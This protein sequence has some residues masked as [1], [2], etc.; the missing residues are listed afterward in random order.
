MRIVVSGGT[1]YI[2]S[3]V[4][5]RCLEHPS[6]T[7][8]LIL[9]RREVKE[10]ADHPKAKVIIVKD[11]TAYEKAIIDEIQT[12]DAA[13]WCLGTSY[14]DER[15]DIEF[16]L[17]FIDIIKA[18]P[19]GAKPFRYVQLSGALTEPPPPEGQ[20]PRSLWFFA[21]GRRV[22]GAMETKVLET[23][24]DDPESRFQMYLV[25]PGG[26]LPDGGAF[27][28]KWIM[29]DTLFIVMKEL[30]AAMVDLAVNGNEQRLFS[31]PELIK[32]GRAVVEKM[33]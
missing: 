23:A 15:V 30:G 33:K 11:F 10:L 28:Q 26:V 27:V 19:A 3:G 20:Q 17:A 9:S 7:S 6:V 22:R 14:G 2:G 32:Y 31:N 25:K 21:N 13:I 1:G 12:A 18:R 24:E 29:G 4:V 5:A 8:V 16:P